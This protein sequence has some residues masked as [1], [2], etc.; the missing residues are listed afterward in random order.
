MP[1]THLLVAVAPTPESQILIK[2]AVSIARPVNAKVSL[3]TLA[4]DPELYNQ[5]AAPMME[6]LREVMQE[7]ERAGQRLGPGA[8]QAGAAEHHI[9]A[10]AADIGPDAV[11]EQFH[12][13]LG[14]VGLE[15]AGTA[16]FEKPASGMAG[17]QRGDVE[18]ARRVEPAMARGDLMA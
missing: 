15:H 7:G 18:L 12:R 17:Q 6:N 1:Y 16:E 9:Y 2:K 4:T 8:F 3:I 10:V 14:A 5:F 13:T 11:P